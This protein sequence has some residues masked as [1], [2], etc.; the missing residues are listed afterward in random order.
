MNAMDDQPSPAPFTIAAPQ[1]FDGTALRGPGLVTVTDGR[2]EA[3]S[4]TGAAPAGTIALP[5]DT[6]LAPGFIDIQVNGGGG[7]LL[8]DEPTEAGIRRIVAAHR[9]FGT[10]GL[11]PTLITDRVEAMEALAQSASTAMQIPGVLGFHLE[12]PALNK[13]RKGIHLETE[14]RVPDARDL[15]AMKSFAGCGRSLVTLAPECVPPTLIGDLAGAGLRVAAGHSDAAAAQISQAADR[16]LTGITHLFNAMSQLTGRAPGVVGAALDDERLFA[17]IICDGLH[18]DPLSLRLACRCKGPDRLM[19]VTD[20]MALV[21][22]SEQHFQLQGRRITLQDGR[23]TGPDGTMAG[24][25]LTMIDA[26]GNAVKWLG[27]DLADALTMASRTP[28]RFLGLE[29]KLGTIAPG[30]RADLVA[31]TGR[32]EIIETWVGG[33]SNQSAAS[34]QAEESS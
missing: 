27:V 8:N 32:F 1:L 11:L 18:V 20:A 19:L 6:I 9:K 4:F 23:L 10:T 33:R 21:G 22:T 25:H 34:Q 12:G 30:Y 2:I 5:P 17:G 24:A 15:A 16:G 14:I 26:V 29:H 7:V 31:F 28:A 3:V 13:A